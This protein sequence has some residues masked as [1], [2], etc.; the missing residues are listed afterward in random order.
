[1]LYCTKYT[2]VLTEVFCAVQ[3]VHT[4]VILLSIFDAIFLTKNIFY[5]KVIGQDTFTCIMQI[6]YALK[7]QVLQY[8]IIRGI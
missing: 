2:D 1:M 7:T 8:F 3:R 4:L 5:R 6:K